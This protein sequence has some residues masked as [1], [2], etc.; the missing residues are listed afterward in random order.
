MRGIGT[1]KKKKKVVA[2]GNRAVGIDGNRG[3]S[4]TLRAR[5]LKHAARALKPPIRSHP[6]LCWM[7]ASRRF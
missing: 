7:I 2:A 4:R 1:G 3:V 5:V 6:M